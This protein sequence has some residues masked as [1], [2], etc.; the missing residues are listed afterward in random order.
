VWSNYVTSML[1]YEQSLEPRVQLMVALT[2]VYPNQGDNVTPIIAAAAAADG[3]GIGNEGL[4]ASDFTNLTSSGMGCGG[5]GWCKQFWRFA[6]T[7]P[8]ELQ[9]DT[10]SS[11]N[12]SGPTGSLVP[13]LPS[14]LNQHTQIFEL[15][16]QDW[17]TAFDPNY[18][19]YGAYHV[20]YAAAI[21]QV[22]SVVG[23]DGI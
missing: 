7:V 2:P 21:T 18:P 3:I 10:A 9:T 11:P 15:Y 14:A 22:A 5:N 23:E 17:L 12:G 1:A 16:L 8:L 6:G 20:G 13:L 19:A 4:R